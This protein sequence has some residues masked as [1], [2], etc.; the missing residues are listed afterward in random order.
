MKKL[1]LTCNLSLAFFA[2]AV[3]A[4]EILGLNFCGTVSVDDIKKSL[5]KNEATVSEEKID[6]ETGMISVKTKD[7]KLADVNAEVTFSIYKGKLY[8]IEF[9]DGGI[10]SEIL[11]SKY[12][13]LR[14]ARENGILIK[15]IYYYNS[16]DKDI[17]IYETFAKFSPSL[18]VSI[19]GNWHYATYLCKPLDRLLTAEIE[20]NEKRKQLQKKGANQL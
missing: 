5:G 11:K 17:D 8:K 10:V 13:L 2:P 15:D 9:A 12:G 14:N 3:E 4:K 20:K 16:K 6:D 1:L 19:G 7:Y 18:G